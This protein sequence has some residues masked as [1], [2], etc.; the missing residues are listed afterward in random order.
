MPGFELTS[1]ILT[2]CE[3]DSVRRQP[4]PLA[5]I[6][7]HFGPHSFTEALEVNHIVHLVGSLKVIPEG[8]P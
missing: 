5:G 6:M 8:N 1:M 3:T 4:V 7:A 2:S